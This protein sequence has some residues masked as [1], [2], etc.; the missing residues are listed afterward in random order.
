MAS[1][2]ELIL[3][4][5]DVT[6]SR[7][8]EL[9]IDVA[10]QSVFTMI[11]YIRAEREG[12]WPLHLEAV[13]QM[14][15]HFCASGHV[16]YAQNGLYYPRSMEGMPREVIDRFIK[17]EHVI[18]THSRCI[19]RYLDIGHV[20]RIHFPW[21]TITFMEESL[22]SNYNETLWRHGHLIS[23]FEAD[24]HIRSKLVEDSARMSDS[25]HAVRQD[26]HIDEQWSR[27]AAE[28][29]NSTNIR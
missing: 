10:I 29:G 13:Q 5:D 17:G 12:D 14:M 7:M 8:A 21:G 25:D 28:T 15:P 1:N 11:Q 26:S 18:V 2:D 4:L 23:I 3:C 24:L 16:K 22:E 6:S 20:R 27:I 9:W 19:E